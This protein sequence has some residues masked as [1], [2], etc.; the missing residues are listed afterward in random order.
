[1]PNWK[2]ID[3][4]YKG[5]TFLERIYLGSEQVW[6]VL[7]P[8]SID[9]KT[10]PSKVSYAVG[11]RLSLSGIKVDAVYN[12]DYRDDVTSQCSFSPANNTVLSSAGV[13]TVTVSFT[14]KG[15]TRTT[16]FTVAVTSSSSFSANDLASTWTPSTLTLGIAEL[17]T[18]TQRQ[19]HS[20]LS[21]S[22]ALVVNDADGTGTIEYS[23]DYSYEPSK[24]VTLDENNE[25]TLTAEDLPDLGTYDDPGGRYVFDGWTLELDPIILTP[26]V[27]IRFS[28]DESYIVTLRA[29][30][31][32]EPEP[33][34][35]E[36]E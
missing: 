30:W 6:P 32:W 4:V 31:T 8:K 7:A 29:Q 9:V 16:S 11:E 35:E 24:T 5:T 14:E 1:M 17:N 36:D 3:K 20:W 34:P 27:S 12:G 13:T 18:Q 33:E 21:A 22:S 23:T 25:Y 19:E 10:M 15:V 26:G 2:Q 28:A